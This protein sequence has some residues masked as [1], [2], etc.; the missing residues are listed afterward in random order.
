MRGVQVRRRSA[1][2]G[3][4]HS[5][6]SA[7]V[8]TPTRGSPASKDRSEYQASQRHA[9]HSPLS[10]DTLYL[11]AHPC[12]VLPNSQ[13]PHPAPAS[14]ECPS[15][16]VGYSI[17]ALAIHDRSVEAAKHLLEGVAVTFAWP[18]GR[19]VKLR[20]SGRISEGSLI[21]IWFGSLRC[22]IQSSSGLSP[23]QAAACLGAE[24]F[25]EQAILPA[26]GNLAHRQRSPCSRPWQTSSRQNLP[27]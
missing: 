20:A 5:R 25:Q 13:A 27:S 6:V 14:G 10:S 22:P 16:K 8:G 23:L 24:N 18:P 12:R 7:N 15:S 2:G 4:R 19:S 3:R 21:T 9:K 17:G 11:D 26:R 1:P